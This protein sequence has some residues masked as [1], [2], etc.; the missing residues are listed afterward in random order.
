LHAMNIGIILRIVAQ[1]CCWCWQAWC[2]PIG[3]PAFNKE[4]TEPYIRADSDA[5]LRV[6]GWGFSQ[7]ICFESTGLESGWSAAL[8]PCRLRG[9]FLPWR[10]LSERSTMGTHSVLRDSF[11]LFLFL[12]QPH[13]MSYVIGCPVSGVLF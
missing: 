7:P 5:I 8:L 10:C 6:L 4:N 1:L 2:M 3:E 11:C 13:F 12:P 9:H